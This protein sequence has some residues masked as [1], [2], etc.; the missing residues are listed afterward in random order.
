MNVIFSFDAF[1]D[2]VK[3]CSNKKL[4][5]IVYGNWY[6]N[7]IFLVIFFMI[8]NYLL[9]YMISNI[10]I[11]LICFF[12][13]F[14]V[15]LFFVLNRKIGFGMA[16]N[17]FVYVMFSYFYK[18]KKVQEIDFSNIKYLNVRKIWSFVLVDMSFID[19]DGKLK[20]IKFRFNTMVFGLSLD[21]HKKNALNIYN[22]L[23][24]L[25]KLNDRG[26]F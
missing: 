17:S 9:S 3:K 2:K 1:C 26:D 21:E 14:L 20:K 13:L 8:L 25:Q 18:I 23:I 24:L 12:V 10:W 16:K 15:L 19:S 5:A 6:G 7:L 22:Q 11:Y 4:L